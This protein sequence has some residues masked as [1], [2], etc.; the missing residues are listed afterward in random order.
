M[1]TCFCLVWIG[2][3]S[4]F[5]GFL[6]CFRKCFGLELLL[7]GCLC[8]SYFSVSVFFLISRSLH[9]PA[10]TQFN[11]KQFRLELEFWY[12][13]LCQG[14]VSFLTNRAVCRGTAFAINWVAPC[15]PWCIWERSRSFAHQAKEK[16]FMLF[17]CTWYLSSVAWLLHLVRDESKTQ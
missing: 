11:I 17:C 7:L 10:A 13:N 6:V 8:L 9:E 3:F 2:C 5:S 15:W 16:S 1:D 4:F 14:D 12:S